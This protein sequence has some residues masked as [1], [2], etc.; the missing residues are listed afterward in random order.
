V[1]TERWTRIGAD[2]PDREAAEAFQMQ[3][4]QMHGQPFRQAAAKV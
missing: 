3:L 2:L 4:E 1:K